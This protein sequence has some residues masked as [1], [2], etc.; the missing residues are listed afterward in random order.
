MEGRLSKN[1]DAAL[2]IT[3]KGSV[4]AVFFANAAEVS[5][6]SVSKLGKNQIGHYLYLIENPP[7]K[8]QR[9][10]T[11]EEHYFTK[12]GNVFLITTNRILDTALKRVATGRDPK[13][14]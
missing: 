12:T 5:R 2:I 13:I 14:R 6:I 9:W 11:A 8:E 3:D 1:Y 10:E 4:D 7:E